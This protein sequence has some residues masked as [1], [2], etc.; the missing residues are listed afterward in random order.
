MKFY[1]K[2]LSTNL[3][4]TTKDLALCP[5]LWLRWLMSLSSFFCAS[6]FVFFVIVL[7]LCV[8]FVCCSLFLNVFNCKLSRIAGKWVA[9]KYYYY[10]NIYMLKVSTWLLINTRTVHDSLSLAVCKWFITQHY[11]YHHLYVTKLR[12]QKWRAQFKPE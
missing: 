3:S 6:W 4:K 8:V 12:E 7:L 10:S 1:P 5:G 11:R 2:W 9:Y